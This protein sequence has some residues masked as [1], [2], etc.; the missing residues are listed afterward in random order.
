MKSKI[1]GLLAMVLWAQSAQAALIQV[2]FSGSLTR[3]NNVSGLFDDLAIGDVFEGTLVYDD[4]GSLTS[5]SNSRNADSDS[6][7]TQARY[8][9]AVQSFV[10]SVGGEQF[11]ISTASTTTGVLIESLRTLM[12]TTTP[13]LTGGLQFFRSSCTTD[14]CFSLAGLDLDDGSWTTGSMSLFGSTGGLYGSGQQTR[15]DG[16]LATWSASVVDATVPEPA[17]L[18]LL[19]IGLA[20]LA[21]VRRRKQQTVLTSRQAPTR[22]ASTSNGL[23]QYTSRPRSP[24]QAPASR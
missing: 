10:V 2:D 8:A 16:N 17:S 24:C 4:N 6:A 13:D 12:S 1:I 14:A 23:S 19:G 18:A 9:S 7:N 15:L 21:A 5:G 22:R 3:I 11:A 20:G